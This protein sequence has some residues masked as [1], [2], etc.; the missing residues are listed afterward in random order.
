MLKVIVVTK[1][2]TEEDQKYWEETFSDVWEGPVEIVFQDTVSRNQDVDLIILDFTK[3]ESG[4]KEFLLS[5]S[6][7]IIG[8][9][10]II[11]STEKDLDIAADA[12]KIG[13]L[14]FLLKPLKRVDLLS[15]LG[16]LTSLIGKKDPTP[17]TPVISRKTAKVITVTSYK[18][19]T[20]VS[21]T[22]VNL[23]YALSTTFQK[24]TLIIDACAYA[25]HISILLNVMPK[26]SIIDLCKQGK[27][28][29]ESYLNHAVTFANKNLGV[30]GG[31]IHH[32]ADPVDTNITI[33]RHLYKIASAQFDYI[34]IDTA[35]RVIDEITM[36]FIR[37]ADAL[38][39]LTT[40]DIL[41]IK[42][43]KFYIQALVE[44]GISGAKIKPIVTRVDSYR[45]NVEPETFQKQLNKS[46]FHTIPNDTEACMNA[47]V[48]AR[49][50][51]IIAPR[52]KIAASFKSLAEKIINMDSEEPPLEISSK[53]GLLSWLKK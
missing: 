20:G 42:D 23:A 10:C 15:S 31:L 52:S 32:K 4:T 45:G 30:I 6:P 8:K 29:D 34:L 24:K 41:S 43:I 26:C 36:F 2:A 22:T 5:L 33:L 51:Q 25:N 44:L 9:N 28:V 12:L 16:R 35:A 19:G 11:F 27:N 48:E 40:M 37:Q 18:G 3:W 21:T 49:P 53:K 13:C 14:S 38:L 1:E 47:T 39:V 46:I 17:S 7:E 50:I